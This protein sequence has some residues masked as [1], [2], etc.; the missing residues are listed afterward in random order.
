MNKPTIHIRDTAAFTR[1]LDHIAGLQ[2]TRAHLVATRDTALQAIHDAHDPAI[3]ALDEDIKA[4]LEAAE[5]YATAYRAELLTG[6]TKSSETT[7]ARWGFRIGQPVL[8]LL[9]R[10]HTWTTVLEAIK[11]QGPDTAAAYIRTKEEPDKEA[12]RRD[13]SEKNL[14]AIGLRC[15]QAETFWTEAKV[16]TGTRLTTPAA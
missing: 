14:A 8:K 12:L 16:E 2:P 7:L 10:K 9:N 6:E 5:T 1:A 11:K 4:H 15:D 13:L 3:A